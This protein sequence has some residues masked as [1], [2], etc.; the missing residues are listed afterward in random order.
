MSIFPS[1]FLSVQQPDV[2][3][4]GLS[5]L[6]FHGGHANRLLSKMVPL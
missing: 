5:V 6:L 4:P 2:L 1:S 3:A